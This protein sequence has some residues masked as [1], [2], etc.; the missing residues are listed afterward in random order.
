MHQSKLSPRGGARGEPGGLDVYIQPRG[1]E[2]DLNEAVQGRE[3]DK[4]NYVPQIE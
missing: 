4:K 2:L 3:L 1:G